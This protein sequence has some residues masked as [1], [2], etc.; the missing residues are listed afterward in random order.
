MAKY[1]STRYYAVAETGLCS[2]DR[3]HWEE[4][5]NCGHAHKTREAAI[6]CLSKKRRMYCE[7]GRLAGLPCKHCL[8]D[9]ARGR[10]TSALWYAGTIHNQNKE[11]V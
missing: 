3:Q 6:K 7:H 10:T 4:W 5:A 9:Y 8:G 1:K 2:L 11:R